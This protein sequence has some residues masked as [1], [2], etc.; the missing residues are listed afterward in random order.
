MSTMK[1]LIKKYNKLVNEHFKKCPN[2]K[3]IKKPFPSIE[4]GLSR[5]YGLEERIK[6]L[7]KPKSPA[8]I[9]TFKDLIPKGKQGPIQNINTIVTRKEAIQNC[10]V[11]YW[12]GN[13]CEHGHL[14]VRYTKSGHCKKCYQMFRK[15]SMQQ[16]N[17]CCD[18]LVEIKDE[19]K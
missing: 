13:P 11:L 18:K 19:T 12:N 9:L 17:M 3:T 16:T 14:S 5:I 10:F 2:T 6:Q 15:G 1:Q 4:I 8:P 7:N